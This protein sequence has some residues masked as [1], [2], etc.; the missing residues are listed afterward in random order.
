M[1]SEARAP[2][3]RLFYA[4]KLSIFSSWSLARKLIIYE[5]PYELR[6]WVNT[7]VF[8]GWWVHLLHAQGVCGSH[9]GESYHDSWPIDWKKNNLVVK[10]LRGAKR[11][12]PPC[13]CSVP[14]WD[15]STVLGALQEPLFEP[16]E[17]IDLLS[18]SL[19][20]TLLLALASVK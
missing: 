3:T 9:H 17:I 18:F 10:F 19:K 7:H 5:K 20:T 16:L 11:L 4:Q 8:A 15:L 1:I 12:N 14:S 6:D 2:S 13:H